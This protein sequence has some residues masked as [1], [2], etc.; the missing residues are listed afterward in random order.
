MVCTK[1]GMSLG[2]AD[3]CSQCNTHNE[4]TETQ[5]QATDKLNQTA[6]TSEASTTPKLVLGKDSKYFPQKRRIPVIIA[7]IIAIIIGGSVVAFAMLSPVLATNA[8]FSNLQ[9]EVNERI[10]ASPFQAFGMLMD[11]LDNGITTINFS[12]REDSHWHPVTAGGSLRFF[13]DS[14]NNDYALKIDLSIDDMDLDFEAYINRERLALRSQI[15]DNNFYGFR[16]ATFR[17]D[18]QSF[19][20]QVGLTPREMNEMADFVDILYQFMNMDH[21]NDLDED[22]YKLFTELLRN[23]EQSSTRTEIISGGAS[24]RCTRIEYVFTAD[25]I[26]KFLNDF[27][28][29]MENDEEARKQFD[30]F[31]VTTFMTYDMYLQEFRDAITEMESEFSGTI[32]VSFYID[33]N[34]RMLRAELFADL[35]LDGERSVMEMTFDFGT[36]VYDPW[37]FEVI[38]T[39]AFSTTK[40]TVVWEFNNNSGTFENKLTIT[41]SDFPDETTILSSMWSPD[42]GDFTIFFDDGWHSDSIEG[43]FTTADSGFHLKFNERD[44]GWGEYLTIEVITE[45]GIEIPQ[46]EFIN[47]DQWDEDLLDRIE[48]A[49]TKLLW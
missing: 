5:T 4:H 18:V 9:A 42:S 21:S 31:Y 30:L 25:D 40:G 8:A 14:Q 37:V 22:Y 39:D 17:D 2:E 46:I 41:G 20:S 35:E 34:N 12:Y 44:L 10:D 43:N 6:S 7:T 32:I 16:Y 45:V 29:V 15:L 38:I 24:V 13:S 47:I 19:G 26:I 33:S 48:D 3:V 11:S 1:C 23:A 28:E 49:F 27:V 36:S